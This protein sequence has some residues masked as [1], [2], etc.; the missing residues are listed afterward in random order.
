MES[1]FGIVICRW[2]GQLEFVKRNA[3]KGIF[4]II[5]I[6]SIFPLLSVKNT[7]RD[8]F[9]SVQLIKCKIQ[10][11]LCKLP[12]SSE[13]SKETFFLKPTF[14]DVRNSGLQGCSKDFLGFSKFQNTLYFLT[15]L[16][17]YLQCSPVRLQTIFVQL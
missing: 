12:T 8:F 14:A 13:Y 11:F 4:L 5:F 2:I 17:M 10:T 7:S 3:I 1:V 9:R 16:I 15:T 6:T